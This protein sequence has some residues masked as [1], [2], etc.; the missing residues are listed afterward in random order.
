[1]EIT[2]NGKIMQT[3]AKTIETLMQNLGIKEKVMATAL[4]MEVVKKEVWSSTF[5]KNGDKIEFLEFVGGG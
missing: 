4:N 3:D 1:M 2:V 5:L